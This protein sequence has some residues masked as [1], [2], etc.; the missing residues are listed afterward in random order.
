M[1]S[2]TS[3]TMDAQAVDAALRTL[4]CAT[5]LAKRYG[6]TVALADCS[7]EVGAGE[8]V[9]V[10]G[11]NGSGKSTLVKI[12]SGVQRHDSGELRI[13][14]SPGAYR[15]P[16]ATARRGVSTVFQEVLVAPQRSVLTNIWLGQDGVFRQSGRAAERRAVAQEVMNSL[17]GDCDLDRP[18]SELTLSAQQ[19]V[20][21]A[22]ALVRTP[23]LLILDEATSALD[24]EVRDRLFVTLRAL[25]ARGSSVLFI[26]H[27]MDEISDIADRAVVLRN[28]YTVAAFKRGEMDP[29]R[30]IQAM[31]G[32]S[33][34]IGEATEKRVRRSAESS[35]ALR[36]DDV[37]VRPDSD[38]INFS[39]YSGEIVGIA[40]LEGQG[41]DLLLETLAG[42]RPSASGQV[43]A[44][45]S[46]APITSID[47]G[48][49]ERVAY[50]PR[51][52][53]SEALLR[54]Q[55]ILDNF[56]LPTHEQ[57]RRGVVLRRRLTRER[58]RQF[59]QELR[60]KAPHP[61]LRI[62]SLSGG[63]QQKVILARWLATQPQVLLLNDPT[64]GIDI[65]AKRD[66]YKVLAERADAGC[67][68]VM[69]STEVDEL[70]ELMDRVLVVRQGSV[71]AELAGAQLTRNR[72]I[73]AYF[74]RES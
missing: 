45:T 46:A 32:E 21:I 54:G 44:G 63:N 28:G 59:V 58:F 66:I 51:D 35:L 2:G 74:G 52:R 14:E 47:S 64:R 56:A 73:S 5:G 41:Q 68:V 55:S 29:A 38:P 36:A 11:E 25:C 39:V 17:I 23:K 43:L 65:T 9:A 24:V 27:R 67:A 4:V 18:T 33:S 12:L 49:R 6:S 53:R 13:D 15:S 30:L 3:E 37:R 61:E 72:L 20:C 7:I 50:L 71:F 69:L 40:G 60:I 48:R 34:L 10:M 57:D 26:S 19:A 42:I 62:E 8:V 1:T 16:R 22:R 70:L 31:S